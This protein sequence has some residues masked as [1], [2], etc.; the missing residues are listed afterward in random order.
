MR[1]N[2]TISF[3]AGRDK[4]REQTWV[5]IGEGAKRSVDFVLDKYDEVVAKK[6]AE[7]KKARIQAKKSKNNKSKRL[8]PAKKEA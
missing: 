3:K 2:N 7:E 5:N 6:E 8:K 1:W 4:A